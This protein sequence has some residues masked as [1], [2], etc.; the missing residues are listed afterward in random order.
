MDHT[1]RQA[2]AGSANKE[3]RLKARMR[4]WTGAAFP[5]AGDGNA[6]V[7][8]CLDLRGQMSEAT[9]S[10]LVWISISGFAVSLLAAIGATGVWILS[11]RK[12]SYVPSPVVQ[13]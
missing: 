8:L 5:Q 6:S 7:V 10:I 4:R 11:N 12:L 9:A 13:S 2:A 1:S 3:R